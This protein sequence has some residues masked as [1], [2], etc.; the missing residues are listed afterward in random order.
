MHATLAKRVDEL[1]ECGWEPLT[2][3]ET[4]AALVGR[5]P[6]NW[7]LFLLVIVFCRF[8][9][10]RVWSSL[11]VIKTGSEGWK[12]RERTP[13]KWDLRVYLADQVLRNASFDVI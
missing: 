10:F 1:V 7:W 8:H 4:S 9:I 5:R 6:F 3:T 12:A 2:T 11:A 13:S